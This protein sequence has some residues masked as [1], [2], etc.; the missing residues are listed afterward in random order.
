VKFVTVLPD[1]NPIADAAVAELRRFGV[2]TSDIVRGTGRM[3]IYYLE[4]GAN[5]RPSKVVYDREHSAI[6]LATFPL[7]I[8]KATSA[9]NSASS[10]KFYPGWATFDGGVR[11]R[12]GG[13][14][15]QSV[16]GGGGQ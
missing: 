13:R 11:R 10:R 14:R 7:K 15:K 1:Q 4:A 9:A 12:D 6:A 16:A 8:Q 3:G 5:Q 2:E